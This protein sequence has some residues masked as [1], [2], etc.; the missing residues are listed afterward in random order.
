M[1]EGMM[2]AVPKPIPPV[3]PEDPVMSVDESHKISMGGHYTRPQEGAPAGS[4]GWNAGDVDF[5]DDGTIFIRNPYLADAIENHLKRNWE[6][7]HGSS[8]GKV[9]YF[10]RIARDR[11][12]WSG[13]LINIVC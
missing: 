13:N 10:I 3:D 12:G 2:S 1:K 4:A 11:E 7:L 6:A 9:K 8:K 5:K